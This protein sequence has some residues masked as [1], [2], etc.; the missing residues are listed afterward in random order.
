MLKRDDFEDV[1]YSLTTAVR[2]GDITT[3]VLQHDRIEEAINLLQ[4]RQKLP[5]YFTSHAKNQS[6]PIESLLQLT[7]LTWDGDIIS[8]SDRDFLIRSGLAQRNN[9][10]S[11][12]TPKGIQYLVDLNLIHC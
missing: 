1:L 9:G 8:K 11:M 7:R 5:Q 3:L 2:V 10:Y 12:V 4:G 6:G